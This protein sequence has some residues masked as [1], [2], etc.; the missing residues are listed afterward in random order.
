MENYFSTLALATRCMRCNARQLTVVY[1]HVYLD[2]DSV[3]Y[4]DCGE[5]RFNY[6]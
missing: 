5:V 2:S 3:V 1:N 4:L 6:G